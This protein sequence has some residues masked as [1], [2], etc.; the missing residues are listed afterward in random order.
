[1]LLHSLG[2]AI[3]AWGV[4]NH[5]EE[6]TAYFLLIVL[7]SIGTVLGHLISIHARPHVIF[8]L[9]SLK[10]WR[11]TGINRYIRKLCWLPD[12]TWTAVVT[13][14]PHLIYLSAVYDVSERPVRLRCRVPDVYW[15]ISLYCDMTHCIYINSMKSGHRPND[16]I[17]IVVCGPHHNVADIRALEQSRTARTPGGGSVIVVQ[18]PSLTGFIINRVLAHS[19]ELEDQHVSFYAKHFFLEPMDVPKVPWSSAAARLAAF[20]GCRCTPLHLLAETVLRSSRWLVFKGLVVA[21]TTSTGVLF[22]AATTARSD[23]LTVS[24][25]AATFVRASAM[26]AGIVAASTAAALVLTELTFWRWIWLRMMKRF[27]VTP[28]DSPWE[29]YEGT[30]DAGDDTSAYMRAGLATLGLFALTRDEAIYFVAHVDDDGEPLRADCEYNIQA[31]TMGSSDTDATRTLAADGIPAAWWSITAY[32]SKSKL[33]IENRFGRYSVERNS[34]AEAGG[35]WT[36]NMAADGVVKTA[37]AG[38]FLPLGKRRHSKIYIALRLYGPHAALASKEML[39]R[40]PLPRI[41]R[42]KRS[43]T[44]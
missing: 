21:S 35:R 34:L 20:F 14:C 6:R 30:G 9:F 16:P 17:T 22:S 28:S 15:S 4:R 5:V 7:C 42:V 29:S 41:C 23:T 12:H 26:V 8:R 25:A 18:S 43:K 33:L 40:L 31:P 3:S 27:S 13:P 37:K 10:V 39:R 36:V 24:A 2:A 11:Q 1:M 44:S 32:D 38:A 19:R